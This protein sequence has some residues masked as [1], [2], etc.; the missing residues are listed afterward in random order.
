MWEKIR[1]KDCEL[2]DAFRIITLPYEKKK[3]EE[4]VLQTYL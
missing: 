1:Q 2:A 4:I 3:I